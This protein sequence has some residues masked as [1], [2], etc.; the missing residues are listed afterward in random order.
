MKRATALRRELPVAFRIP[1]RTHLSPFVVR[2]DG[3]A[4]VQVFRLDGASF[5]SADDEVLNN[6]HERLNVLWRN[7][8]APNVSLWTHVV[9]RRETVARG[10]EA[11][12][13]CSD[14]AE[15]LAARYQKR[16]A[17]ETLMLNEL[18]LSVVYQPLTGA[19]PNLLARLLPAPAAGAKA[20]ERADALD[21]C[22]KLAQTID[23]SLARYEPERLGVYSR[24]ARQYSRPLEFFALLLNGERAA[25]PLPVAP[26]HE[27]LATTRPI[28]GSETIEY[29]LP[30]RTRFGAILGLLEYATPSEVGM[31][32]ALLSAPFEFVLTQSFAFLSR[33][34]SQG[35]LQRQA[36]QMANAG[37]FAVSQAAQLQ[38]ALDDLTSNEFV[39]G[40]HHFTLQVLTPTAA[41]ESSTSD[42]P[43]LKALNDDLA[44]ARAIL[45][46]TGFTTARED[47][48]LEAAFWAQL[49]GC[50]SLRPRKA[51]ITSRNFC[52]MAPFHN[53]PAGRAS[54]N[55]WGEALATLLTSARSPYY[56]SLHASDP[57]DPDGGSRKDT[58][59]TFICGP[60]GSGKSVLIG[61][62]VALL[63]R[64]GATQ[65]L[66][67]K[68]RGLE[69]LTR[70]LGG[71][72][73]PLTN[74]TPTGFNPL[75]LEPTAGNVEFLKTWLRALVRGTTPLTVREEADLDAALSGT[76]A[77]DRP[78]RRLSRLIEFTDATRHEG[79]HA[80]LARWCGSTQGA[81]AWVFDNAEDS[82]VG[83]LQ[84]ASL[85]GVD[86]TDFLD[87]PLTRAP[88]TLYLFQ[89][90]RQLLDGRRFVCWLDEFWK[91]LADPAF[92]GF[93]KDGP[94]TWRK[95]NG[96]MCLAT[97]S[98][99][100]VLDSP[101][102][103]TI[104]EQ[105]PTKI[106][107][108]NPDANPAEYMD[109]FGLSEREFRLLKEQLEPGSRQFLVKQGH[110]STVCQ[111]DLKGFEAEI[112]VISGRASTVEE[113]QRLMARTGPDPRQWLPVFL[114]QEAA[115]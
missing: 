68:D 73:L 33:A 77:L 21:A 102:S 14:F 46:D 44:R 35:L 95:L 40:D 110:Y 22:D 74:G 62:L 37:D 7:I 17:A 32:D 91:L 58:G 72:Y 34:T 6:W 19:A 20:T 10:C 71:T 26:I 57:R 41:R 9:R 54:G 97:Q 18:Y 89:V 28:F 103:R 92:E 82:L 101:I 70:A 24:G 12:G 42:A 59:H 105:T 108:P 107:F 78:A 3:G 85:F 87:H 61:F 31:F 23:S 11:V 88:V 106:L 81:Y 16:L 114:A 79:I 15:R 4:Y 36:N 84:Q 65:V 115:S 49:P 100:D 8:A 63:A 39:L 43:R 13:A 5:E 29:R 55:H 86:V 1:Y 83:S 51:P 90:I 112:K 76:L 96:V 27:V 94:K 64:Q 30:T 2:T 25:V 111:L 80:R 52:A 93:A 53:F 75:Q 60:T 38:D 48:A 47:L 66:F 67:D 104:V 69:I 98:A 50:F 99:S 45:A 113:L 56:F 109:G